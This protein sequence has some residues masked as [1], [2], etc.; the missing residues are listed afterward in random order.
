MSTMVSTLTGTNSFLLQTELHT[1]VRQFLDEHGDMALE[2]LDGEETSYDR[3]REALQSLPFLATKKLVVLRSPSSQK[4]FM[5]QAEQLLGD[6]SDATDVIIVEPKLDKRTSYAKY[7]QKQTDYQEYKELDAPALSRWLVD[8]AK[9]AGARLSTADASYL[10]NR[11]GPQQQLLS[12]ELSKLISASP[13]IDR[14][15][16]DGLTEPV[17]QSSTFDLLEAAFSGD[18]QRTLQ[19]YE[20]QRRQNVEPQAIVGLLSWQL[21][22]LAVCAW[23]GDDHNAQDIARD[24][25]LH[26]F[27]VQKSLSLARR[28]GKPRLRMHIERLASLDEAL[29]TSATLA[30]DAVQAYLLALG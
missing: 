15:L 10:V 26:P 18:Y 3:M 19:L 9:A 28:I 21:H 5:E 30:D 29:K 1:R 20:E 8:A 25:K 24:A 17:P 11:L 13:T 22:V 7:L 23:A 14:K 27:V 6:L 2:R 4:E 16:I 12:T